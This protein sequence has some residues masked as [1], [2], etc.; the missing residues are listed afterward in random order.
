MTAIISANGLFSDKVLLPPRFS[1]LLRHTHSPESSR[2][3]A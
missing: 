3:E 1:A 2:F